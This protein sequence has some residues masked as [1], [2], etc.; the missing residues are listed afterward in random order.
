V[1]IGNTGNVLL[2]L[3][4]FFSSQN[5][6]A[7]LIDFCAAP[8]LLVLDSAPASAVIFFLFYYYMVFK[9]KKLGK[10]RN[11]KEFCES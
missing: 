9:K 5:F 6:S 1:R 2:K 7:A 10:N 3:E 4:I 8:T 11:I